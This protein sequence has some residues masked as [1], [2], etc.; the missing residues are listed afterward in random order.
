MKIDKFFPTAYPFSEFVF[1]DGKQ[2]DF[3]DDKFFGEELFSKIDL[4]LDLI[5]FLKLLNDKQKIIFMFFLL[6]EAGYNF[7]H[8]QCASTMQISRSLYLKIFRE[9]K[10]KS[11][12]FF[13]DLSAE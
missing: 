1:P 7:N 9:V 12:K 13:A 11:R 10:K 4:E 2:E 5:S 6:R 8:A 3:A